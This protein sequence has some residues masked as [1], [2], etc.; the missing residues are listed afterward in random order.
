MS[1]VAVKK[2][3]NVISVSA[4]SIIIS[5]QTNINNQG[6]GN[7]KSYMKLISVNG[8]I[9]GTVGYCD[10]GS[11]I[12]IFAETHK[13]K[14]PTIES[15]TKFIVEFRK[16]K[17]EL[18]G[19]SADLSEFILVYK[20]HIFSIEGLCVIEINKFTAIGAGQEYA[21]AA[22]YLGH[23]TKEAVKVTCDL[24]CYVEEPI[25]TYTMTINEEGVIIN[26]PTYS[27]EK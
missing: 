21:M 14:D 16:F 17:Q 9:I 26:G 4:D 24:C 8:M 19:N 22:L 2:T 3:K 25:I 5:F 11:L 15:V 6:D 1:V 12:S 27:D 23:S 18:G 7:K 10:D 20:G 13:P